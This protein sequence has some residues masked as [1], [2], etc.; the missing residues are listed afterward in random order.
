MITLGIDAHKR[1]HT[2]VAVDELGRQLGCRTTG[3]TTT[4]DHRALIGWAEGF[5]AER[6]W[7]VED[8]RQLSRRLEADML[9]A[10]ERI[11]RVP[12]KL[13]AH[14]RDAA[15]TYGKSDPIDALAVARAAQREPDLP[16]AHLDAASR[17]IRLL[18]DHRDDLVAERTRCINRLRWHLHEIDPAFDP[19][20]GALTTRKHLDAASKRV[21][22]L[23]TVVARIAAELIERIRSLNATIAELGDELDARTAHAAPNLR[24]VHGV[25]PPTAAKI[26]GETAGIGRFRS[27]HAYA[28]H[29]GTAPLP[30]WSSNTHRH[31][32]SRAGNR[33]LNAAIHRI[34]LT[35]ASN[36]PPARRLLDRRTTN[37]NT[38]KEA[39]RV[40]KRR[41]SD[42][43]YRALN[44]DAAHLQ[45]S[46]LLAA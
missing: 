28:R 33:Q 34:A 6:T 22:G 21:Q 5:G 25:G 20:A 1:T 30:V 29:N 17:E 16:A 24:S 13:M 2:V 11:V 15:R 19:P 45:D 46:Q 4:T 38:K 9:A 36:H 35:Q 3:G 39:M 32:L 18:V 31:R 27:R 8:C 42:V 44:A 10:G 37:G 26:I 14:A 23:D 7:A 43:V 40:L 41:L 12:P